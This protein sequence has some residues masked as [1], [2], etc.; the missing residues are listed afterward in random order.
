MARVFMFERREFLAY[1]I[2][3][4]LM[5]ND[6]VCEFFKLGIP[7]PHGLFKPHGVVIGILE[8]CRSAR[9][10]GREWG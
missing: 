8:H 1:Y 5:S 6:T 10:G 9:A 3:F 4:I 2:G 7:P